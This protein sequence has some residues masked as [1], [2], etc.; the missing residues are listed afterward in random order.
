MRGVKGGRARDEG[1]R[2]EVRD[3]RVRKGTA[4]NERKMV[5]GKRGSGKGH[6]GRKEGAYRPMG[7][8]RAQVLQHKASIVAD[9]LQCIPGQSHNRVIAPWSQREVRA[10]GHKLAA[11]LHRNRRENTR[12]T[13][14]R[15]THKAVDVPFQ[16]IGGDGI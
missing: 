5:K 6:K 1:F 16:S 10:R 14:Q 2:T 4:T 9:D 3:E 15:R 11:L 12:T 8:L 7:R 13:R